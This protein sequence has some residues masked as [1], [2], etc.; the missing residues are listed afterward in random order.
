MISNHYAFTYAGDYNW[1]NLLAIV[2]LGA[3]IRVYFVSRHKANNKQLGTGAA[4]ITPLLI[5]AGILAALIYAG[6]PASLPSTSSTATDAVSMEE[7]Q[8]IL[9]VHCVVCHSAQPTQPG[10]TA[11]P[12]GV[13]FDTQ[14]EINKLA[15]QIYQQTVI[16]KVMPIGNLTG[17]TEAERQKIASWIQSSSKS[18]VESEQ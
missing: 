13:V 9:Q 15:Q 12:L 8:A 17:M 3:L 1:V 16:S 18:Q 11:P 10:F 4:S 5:A 7:V 2:L 14:A 6:L